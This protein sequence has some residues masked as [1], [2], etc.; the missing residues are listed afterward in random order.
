MPKKIS[1]MFE[2]DLDSIV[3]ASI[4][5]NPKGSINIQCQKSKKGNANRYATKA[6]GTRWRMRMPDLIF[7][8]TMGLYKP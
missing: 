4:K 1:F 3:P 6:P 2:N 8:S 7:L 5:Y